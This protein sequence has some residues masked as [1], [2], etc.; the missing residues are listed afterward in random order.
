MGC[1][2]LVGGEARPGFTR[3]GGVVA[4]DVRVTATNVDVSAETMRLDEIS[5]EQCELGQRR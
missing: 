3:E 2:I 5:K 4:A 1:S